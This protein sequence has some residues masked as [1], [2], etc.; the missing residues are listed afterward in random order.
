[1]LSGHIP[2]CLVQL[3]SENGFSDVLLVQLVGVS[4]GSLTRASILVFVGSAREGNF[5]HEFRHIVVHVEIGH[6]GDSFFGDQLKLLEIGLN[7]CYLQ[8]PHFGIQVFRDL[9]KIV[10][11]L[12]QGT[13]E[14]MLKRKH[15]AQSP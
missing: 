6:G 14:R 11:F 7:V 1:M 10:R 4:L 5:K 8:V 9:G 12:G 13:F 15:R 2:I 3:T